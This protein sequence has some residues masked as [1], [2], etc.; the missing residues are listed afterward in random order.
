MD[1]EHRNPRNQGVGNGVDSKDAG[2]QAVVNP[3]RVLFVDDEAPIREVMRIELPRMG[4]E[5]TVCEDGETALEVLAEHHFDAAIVD[6]KMPGIS[7]WEVTDHIKQVSPETF[8][9]IHTGHGDMHQAIEAVRH[10]ANDF[11]N[12]PCK[13]V[14]IQRALARAAEWRQ[15]SRKTQALETRLKAIEG[16]TELVGQTPA[17]QQVAT[18]IERVAP[19]DSSVLVLGETGTGKE[20]VARRVHELSARSEMPFVPVNCGALP[21]HLVE[22]EFFGHRKGAFTGA[23]RSRTGLFEVA[24]GGTLFLDEL[25]EL[26]KPMQVK[27]LR[28]LESGEIRRVGE[29]EP[30]H[31]DVRIV[32]ATNGDL[33]EMVADGGF[34]EDLYFRVNT[35]EIPL[36]PLRDRKPDLPLLAAA[37]LTRARKRPVDDDEELS[38]EVLAGLADHDWPGNVRELAN[39][40]EHAVI[41]AGDRPVSVEHLPQ[42]LATSRPGIIS[43]FVMPSGAMTLREVERQ[44]V[45][46]VL[47]K[48]GGDKRMA[49]EELG[50]ALKTM[51]NKLNQ[52]NA[53]AVGESSEIVSTD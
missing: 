48:H 53:S 50:I 11:L 13:L 34:R 41:M 22:S 35:F 21:E 42:Q 51:Y 10:R 20:L 19:T 27:L 32:C 52:Y 9:I 33:A 7:G 36:P 29:N 26:D 12:K 49:S 44:V 16:S 47:D 2:E 3:L 46:G 37:L 39:A 31:V 43:T 23:D 4:H 1:L 5:V 25:G 15:Q 30:I 8:V 6:L 17:M 28:F 18:L 14:D 38:A 45:L 24:H 40:I